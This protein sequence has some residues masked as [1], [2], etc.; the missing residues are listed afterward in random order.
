MADKLGKKRPLIDGSDQLDS[1]IEGTDELKP[2]LDDPAP[3]N[4]VVDSVTSPVTVDLN[5]ALGRKATEFEVINDG[6]G[7]FTV[8]TSEDGIAFSSERTTNN[9]ESYSLNRI[10][11][12][13]IRLTRVTDSNARVDS[14]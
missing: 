6:P 1:I 4:V 13:S 7:I 11:V 5:T 12:D 8:A 3:F 2:R 14:L 10:S 9:G